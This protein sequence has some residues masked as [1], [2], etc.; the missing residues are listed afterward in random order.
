MINDNTSPT[1]RARHIDVW[2]FQLQDWRIDDGIIMVYI[3][4]ILN[5]SDAETKPLG[6]VLHSWHCLC[7]MGHYDG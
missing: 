2:Y 1:E 6:F 5:L 3:K 7:M 4:G